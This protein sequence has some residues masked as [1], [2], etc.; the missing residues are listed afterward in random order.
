MS[1]HAVLRKLNVLI[2]FRVLFVSL[3]LAAF[4]ILQLEYSFFPYPRFLLYL[5][6][7]TYCLNIAYLVLLRSGKVNP[8]VQAYVQHSLD[9]AIG[10]TLIFATGGI[11]SWFTSVLLLV[12]ISSYIV[13]GNKA[14]WVFAATSGILYGIA[15]DLQYYRLIPVAYSQNLTEKDFLFHIVIKL[16]AIYLVAYL[17]RYLT[18]G[19]ER[20]KESLNQ[21]STDLNSLS[22]FHEDVIENIPSGL[23][24]SDMDGNVRLFNRAAE[25]IT[26]ISREKALAMNIRNIF[27]F[28]KFPLDK[29]PKRSNGTVKLGPGRKHIGMSVSIHRNDVGKPIGYIG[30]FQDL[31]DIVRLENEIKQRE[32]FAAIGELAA[33]IAHEIRNPLASLRG[34]IEIIKENRIGEEHKRKLMDIAVDEISRLNTIITEFLSY[35]NPK[36]PDFKPRNLSVLLDTTVSLLTSTAG[37]SQEISLSVDIEKDL[38]ADIDEDKMRQVFWNLLTNALEAMHGNGKISIEARSDN[39]Y[40][41]TEISDTG[42]GISEEDHERVFYPFFTTK[43]AGTGLGLAIVYRIIEDHRGSI[44]VLSSLGQ[45]ATFTIRIPVQQDQ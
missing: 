18:T 22:L 33:N 27:S 34:S 14:G 3:L 36:S 40:I 44:E 5:I 30:T 6:I 11:D 45:G 26:G 24:S 13:T 10:L 15:I 20:T 17:I 42:D 38:Y 8:L 41:V 12:V 1:H 21:K 31:T 23:L 35:S 2:S 43:K 29:E 28:I 32:K 25:Y 7:F 4:F 39:G 9:V 16:T 37:L 19:L